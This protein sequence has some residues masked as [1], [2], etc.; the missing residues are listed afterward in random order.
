MAKRLNIPVYLYDWEVP[1]SW[2][3]EKKNLKTEHF[4]KFAKM[5]TSAIKTYSK[6]GMR[7][8]YL[9]FFGEQ[10][11]HWSP[12]V[13]PENYNILVKK[14]RHELDAAGFSDV[15][16]SGPVVVPIEGYRIQSPEIIMRPLDWIY[17]LDPEG[18][19]AH[20]FLS[21]QGHE[22]DWPALNAKTGHA[23]IRHCWPAW[24]EAFNKINPER[25]VPILINNYNT[26]TSV[27]HGI[28]YNQAEHG[29]RWCVFDTV[30]AAVRMSEYLLSFFNCG[31]VGAGLWEAADPI[32]RAEK[33]G[34]G[35]LRS[36]KYG[37]TPRPIYYAFKTML[38]YIPKGSLVIEPPYQADDDMYSAVFS[39]DNGITVVVTN[40]TEVARSKRIYLSNINGKNLKVVNALAF[41]AVDS[42]Y[43]PRITERVIRLNQEN[44]GIYDF[45]ATLLSDSVLTIVLSHDN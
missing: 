36:V 10:N 1:T 40:N 22:F 11:G 31:A 41:S 21:M 16:I 34:Y 42:V 27:F 37:R 17:G 44:P 20:A 39:T 43:E 35:I 25:N 38:P 12:G 4:D 45:S 23:H 6:A 28:K 32:Y 5:W 26:Y 19:S 3:D 9:A 30:P 29:N 13:S 2:M 14:V 33:G 18:V 8:K 7:P 24:E 15:G